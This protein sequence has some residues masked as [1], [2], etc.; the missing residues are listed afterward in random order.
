K[1]FGGSAS[2]YQ[3]V[4]KEVD[5]LPKVSLI[6]SQRVGPVDEKKII[7]TVLEF[8]AAKKYGWLSTSF[9][10]K[11]QTLHVIRR[12]PYLTTSSKILPLHILK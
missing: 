12:E 2:D 6:I 3:L 4:E 1:K 11:G 9:W 8:L 5:G 7:D 10:E